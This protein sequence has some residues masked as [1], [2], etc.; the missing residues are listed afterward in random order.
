MTTDK[1][2]SIT[3]VTRSPSE[4]L[5]LANRLVAS[6]QGA[7]VLA[8]HGEL[9][10]GK[11]CFVQGL[12]Q[13]MGIRDAITSPTFTLVGEYQGSDRTL[14]HFDLYRLHD[15]DELWALG[16]D[17]Y[18]NQNG[19]VAIEWAERAEDTLPADTIHVHFEVK[20]ATTERCIRFSTLPPE[21]QHFDTVA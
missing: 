1:D 12:G 4:T 11:T 21:L 7:L 14:Y 5:Q 18:L 15:A 19:I 2:T 10:A 8:L 17:E 13:A 9:G 6:T 3:V 20:D 16:F